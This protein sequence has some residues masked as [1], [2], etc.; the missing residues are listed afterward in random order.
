M[1]KEL[2]NEIYNLINDEKKEFL[3]T[4]INS[5]KEWINA[6][7][8]E[9]AQLEILRQKFVNDY[10]MQSFMNMK[11]EEYVVGYGKK[12]TFCYRIENELRRLG[13]IHGATSSKFGMYFGKSGKDSEHKY[14][15]TKR[16]NQDPDVAMQEIAEQ[17]ILLRMAGEEHNYE[18]IRDSLFAPVFRGKIL[19]VYFP[20]EYLCIFAEDHLDYFL[21]KLNIA[22]DDTDDEL[23]KQ[24][25]LLDYKNSNPIMK[26]WTTYIFASFLYI[27]FGNP[28]E[29]AKE[30][31]MLQ[32][33]RDKEYPKKYVSDIPV[34]VSQWIELLKDNEIFYPENIELIKRF[35]VGDNH[36]KTC[37]DLSIE[38]GG[39]SPTTY[40]SP[41][42]ALAKRISAKMNLKPI[43][44][45]DG[46]EVWWRVVFW[47]RIR[48]DNRFEWKVRPELA[49]ALESICP[50]LELKLEDANSDL[51]LVEDLKQATLKYLK[52]DFTYNGVPKKKEEAVYANGRKVYPRS[53]QV[54]IN[55]LAHAKHMCEISNEHPTFIRKGSDKNYT[56]PHHLVPMAYSDQFEV[57]LDVEENIVSLCSNCH[58]QLHYGEG[59][60]ELLDKLYQARK[61][62][63]K[64]VGI[65]ISLNELKKM[66]E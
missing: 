62:D 1:P 5:F 3:L 35:Y 28:S 16:F 22:Y 60:G 9:T 23:S 59:A 44:A 52:E 31:K 50:E 48:E 19:S 14:R 4:K 11:K 30:A 63:L 21:N 47:G 29:K 54:A 38:D 12:D 40:I 37:Y 20:E 32:K 41:I 27:T 49:I 18:K 42:V 2:D 57:S 15:I 53:R 58:N 25:K 13:D 26:K 64:K 8:K 46:S 10:N 51:I 43:I 55:A 34:N 33:E 6:N 36:A 39:I 7:K 17:I 61:E 24:V 66:Y 45:H 65:I 56:E